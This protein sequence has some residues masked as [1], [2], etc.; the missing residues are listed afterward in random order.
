MTHVITHL[1]MPG[2]RLQV[3]FGA[4]VL[5]DADGNR[6]GNREFVHALLS[7]KSATRR[8]ARQTAASSKAGIKGSVEERAINGPAGMAGGGKHLR[9]LR[10]GDKL[11]K[12]HL[13]ACEV[14][15]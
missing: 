5:G 14:A 9:F 15:Q 12:R 10:F 6:W 7:I 11:F 1:H 4:P 8:T 3:Q 13:T 2:L